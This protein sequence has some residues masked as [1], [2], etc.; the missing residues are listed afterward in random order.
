[1]DSYMAEDLLRWRRQNVYASDDD[2]VFASETM[3][4]KQPY[5][6]D[7][8][9]KRHI[10]PVAKVNDIQY[11]IGVFMT[12]HIASTQEPLEQKFYS[13]IATTQD[14]NGIVTLINRAFA[15]ENPYLLTD[16]TDL[17]EI[18]GL[19][20]KGHLLLR[21][22]AGKLIA[23]IYAEIRGQSRAYLGL[24]VVE[25]T[26]RRTGIGKQL[27]LAGEHFCRQH[28]VAVVAWLPVR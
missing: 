7:N 13:R 8:L 28:G 23:L 26:K 27:L 3:R 9:M 12:T 1:M 17:D 5:W 6:P 15:N 16:R 21:E 4:G 18:R 11:F 2:Y 14:L 22:E 19:M 20:Q 24:L 25:P 10:Q